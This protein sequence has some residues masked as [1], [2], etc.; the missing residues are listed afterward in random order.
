[1][2]K[3]LTRILILPLLPLLFASCNY[4]CTDNSTSL[5]VAGF[6]SSSTKQKIS[7]ST[8]TVGGVGAYKDSLLVNNT[9]ASQTFLPFRSSTGE[10]KFFFHYGQDGLD[11]D[12]HNDTITFN[13]ESYPYF[14]SEECGAMYRYNIT[15]CLYTT[16]LINKVV[17]AD[18]LITNVGEEHIQIYFQT[19][20]TEDK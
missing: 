17:I 18:S 9:S 6:Y 20:D 12:A 7:I 8:I 13:Y 14:V 16:K 10:V 15:R 3:I 11:D 19:F 1:M 5:P 2:G 4:T